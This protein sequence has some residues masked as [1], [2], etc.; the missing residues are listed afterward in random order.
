MTTFKAGDKI[1]L[2][3]SAYA[4]FGGY[5]NDL[6]VGE[7]A[8]VDKVETRDG[9]V[10]HF[11][12]RKGSTQSAYAHETELVSGDTFMKVK[13]LVSEYFEKNSEMI[14]TIAIILLADHYFF[15]GKFKAKVEDLVDGLLKKHT[16][17]DA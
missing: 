14:F 11:F 2:K 10:V 4:R 6:P 9:G 1:K 12:T 17:K 8:L 13:Q 7:T 5:A 3:P 15:G 16:P